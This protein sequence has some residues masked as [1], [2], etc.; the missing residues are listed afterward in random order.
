MESI[1]QKLTE[2]PRRGDSVNAGISTTIMRKHQ[3]GDEFEVDV[4]ITFTAT[5]TDPG[6]AGDR[7]DP[8][9]GAEIEYEI[10]GI[11]LDLPS[12]M[13]TPEAIAEFGGPL[14]N[15]E[16]HQISQWFK[17]HEDQAYDA[18]ADKLSNY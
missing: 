6:Y 1:S 4:W 18:A 10:D 13:Q 14:T 17:N 2:R 3:D 7:Y 12:N 5:V 15:K 16:K 11:E 9:S 8:P